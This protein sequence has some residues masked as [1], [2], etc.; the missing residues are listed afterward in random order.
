MRVGRRLIRLSITLAVFWIAYWVWIYS[1][2]CF[3]ANNGTLWCPS[4]GDPT[5]TTL[6]RTNDWRMAALV[7]L[8][9]IWA[10]LLGILFWWTV[11]GFQRRSERKKSGNAPD[12]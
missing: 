8:P 5:S 10:L 4:G 2:K 1:T 11:Q 6:V 12:T 3:H 7:L 9:P